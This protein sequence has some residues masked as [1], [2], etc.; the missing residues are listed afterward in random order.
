[1]CLEVEPNGTGDGYGTH[2]SV[3]VCLMKG[4]FDSTLKW[5]FRGEVTFKLIDQRLGRH[6]TDVS[7]FN[8]SS[9]DCAERVFSDKGQGWG[10]HTFKEYKYL[11]PNFLHNDCLQFEVAEVELY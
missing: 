11:P 10:F 9:N 1:M 7:I 2:L 8:D 6:Y 5:P 4:E 3:Y